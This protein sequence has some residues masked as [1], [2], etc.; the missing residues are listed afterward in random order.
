MLKQPQV[1]K[2]VLLFHAIIC[3]FLV[4]DTGGEW[5][6]RKKWQSVTWRE[7]G[8]K[9]AILRVTYF[10]NDL[11]NNLDIPP[12]GTKDW[13]S[14]FHTQASEIWFDYLTILTWKNFCFNEF[15]TKIHWNTRLAASDVFQF[16]LIALSYTCLK[17]VIHQID[18][19]NEWL[20]P[21][22]TFA[23]KLELVFVLK[24]ENAFS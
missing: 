11:L 8:S 3:H 24:F 13:T 2:C 9:D 7:E 16:L 21:S 12:G 20:L 15:S 1:E 10:L 23:A 19:K 17:N 18:S 22:G 4:N 6:W 14:I 5:V